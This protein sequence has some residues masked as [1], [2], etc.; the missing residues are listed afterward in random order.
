MLGVPS[1]SSTNESGIPAA[2]AAAAA[3]DLVVFAIGSDLSLE[4]EAHDRTVT[5]FSAAQLA[6]IAAVTA[7]IKAPI[8]ALVFSGG[9]MDVSPLLSNPKA[10]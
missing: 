7:S 5:N 4:K 10:R 3:A 9:A 6:L 1:V 2:A 8:I